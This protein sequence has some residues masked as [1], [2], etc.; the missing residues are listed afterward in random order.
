MHAR[1]SLYLLTH[2]CCAVLCRAMPAGA[3]SIPTVPSIPG[4]SGFKGA[5]MHTATWDT[6][7]DL[8]GKK[9]AVVGT[10]ASAIQA[11]PHLQKTAR[12]LVVFQ[13]CGC[14]YST[15]TI[16]VGGLA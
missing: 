6:G 10:G 15:P 16:I 13:V 9:V 4:L 5:T 1:S 12:E 14:V 11:I 8:A 3:L 7:V 2:S